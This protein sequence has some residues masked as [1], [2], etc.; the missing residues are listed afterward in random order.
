[1]SLAAAVSLGP[2]Q[3]RGAQTGPRRGTA[4]VRRDFTAR[5][6]HPE[7]FP[8]V[9]RALDEWSR[10]RFL[11]AG[12]PRAFFDHFA[13]TSVLLWESDELVGL[14]VGFQS[15]RDP[16]VAHVHY[17]AVAPQWRRRGG[18]R[19]LYEAFI[20][21]ARDRGCREIQL[22]VP[23]VHSGLIAFHRQLGFEV[24]GADGFACGIAVCRD[25]AGPGQHRVLFRRTL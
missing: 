10:G 11:A 2:K 24:N 1:M 9:V 25:Y 14:L 5:R 21:T 3:A 19:R 4:C 17:V 15:P 6:L 7:D 8:R 12:L 23:P 18:G 16:G 22:A 20:G 13:D